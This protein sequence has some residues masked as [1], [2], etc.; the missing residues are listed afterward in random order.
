[1]AK[2]IL[3]SI[4]LYELRFVNQAAESTKRMY[5]AF[6]STSVSELTIKKAVQPIFVHR[7][8]PQRWAP[9]LSFIPKTKSSCS[10]KSNG[11]FIILP[12]SYHISLAY[13]TKS[14]NR[15]CIKLGRHGKSTSGFLMFCSTKTSSEGWTFA[16]YH[17]ARKPRSLIKID[18]WQKLD[19]TE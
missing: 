18:M 7:Q 15:I 17:S 5:S 8:E 10:E 12:R 13:I 3:K 2:E 16:S 11:I 1:M 19:H 4:L 9:W 14:Y 6:T